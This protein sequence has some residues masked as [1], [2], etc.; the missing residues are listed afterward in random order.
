MNFDPEQEIL[1][2]LA[3]IFP[4]NAIYKS[5]SNW[6]SVSIWDNKS[7]NQKFMFEHRNQREMVETIKNESVSLYFRFSFS[8]FEDRSEY[9]KKENHE[10]Q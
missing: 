4:E 5:V 7:P 9:S 6:G 8:C 3:V 10:I 1:A 2:L